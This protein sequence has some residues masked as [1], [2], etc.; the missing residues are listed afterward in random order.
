MLTVAEAMSASM[1]WNFLAQYSK[2]STPKEMFAD[3]RSIAT[4]SSTEPMEEMEEEKSKG[5]E[6]EHGQSGASANVLLDKGMEK[7]EEVKEDGEKPAWIRQLEEFVAGLWLWQEEEEANAGST[8][9]TEGW[10]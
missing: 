1:H 9:E 2:Y 3:L 7:K 5:A 6:E 10:S 4:T 8:V